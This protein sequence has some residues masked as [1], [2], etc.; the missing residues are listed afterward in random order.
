MN[1]IAKIAPKKNTEGIPKAFTAK[2]L[3]VNTGYPS[4]G[5]PL[6]ATIAVSSQSWHM[7]AKKADQEQDPKD[8]VTN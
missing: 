7:R 8:S 2:V 6:S 3:T 1:C 4:L 5:L